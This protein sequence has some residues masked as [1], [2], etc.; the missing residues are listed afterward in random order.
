MMPGLQS[1]IMLSISGCVSD[2]RT[3]TRSNMNPAGEYSSECCGRNFR[4]W[5]TRCTC[6]EAEPHWQIRQG[7]HTAAAP[8]PIAHRGWPP[9]LLAQNEETS[10]QAT[11]VTPRPWLTGY[12]SLPIYGS[13]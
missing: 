1:H 7:P 2:V 6:L 13:R 11:P 8:Y 10:Q 3:F 12:S 4:P 5:K 9:A